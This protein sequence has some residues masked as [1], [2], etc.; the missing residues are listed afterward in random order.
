MVLK[1]PVGARM[2]VRCL[3]GCS[4]HYDATH[5]RRSGHRLRFTIKLG[6]TRATIIEMRATKAGRLGRYRRYRF[7]FT[8]VG[9]VARG[10]GNG[11]CLTDAA[12]AK[13]TSCPK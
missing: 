4:R 11:G 1:V 2:R 13:I 3:H 7:R 9:L 6:V 12:K 10:I 8:T 5:L